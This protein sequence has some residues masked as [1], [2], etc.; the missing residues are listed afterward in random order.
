MLLAN[1]EDLN[2]C[3]ELCARI[4]KVEICVASFVHLHLCLLGYICCMLTCWL[5]CHMLLHGRG[6]IKVCAI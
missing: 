4:T 2:S 1:V 5:S 6:I 3:R